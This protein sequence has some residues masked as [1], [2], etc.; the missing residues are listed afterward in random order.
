MRAKR[1]TA[2]EL[3]RNL[4]AVLSETRYQDVSH[5]IWRGKEMVARLEPPPR[6]AAGFP[7]ER[8]NGLLASLP[9][10]DADEA[11]AFLAD[12][13]RIDEAVSPS[14]DPWVS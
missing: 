10:L 8:L 11:D 6:A 13:Q 12:V 9:R 14:E 7:I 1:I 5:E 2:T 4:S 3:A